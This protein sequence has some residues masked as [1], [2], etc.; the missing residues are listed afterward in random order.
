[1][2]IMSY[3]EIRRDFRFGAS[4]VRTRSARIVAVHHWVEVEA[5]GAAGSDVSFAHLSQTLAVLYAPY[6]TRQK[7]SEAFLAMSRINQK[8]GWKI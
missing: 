7:V 3:P 5:N 2:L 4:E 6:A 8:M 1:M